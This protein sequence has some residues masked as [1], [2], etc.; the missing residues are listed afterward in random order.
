MNKVINHMKAIA[1]KKIVL[2]ISFLGIS[3]LLW[4]AN[5]NPK[6]ALSDTFIF[7]LFV[8]M[9]L[10][11][12]LI[13]YVM[14]NTLKSILEISDIGKIGE[15]KKNEK[16]RGKKALSTVVIFLLSSQVYSQSAAPV[17][18][19]LVTMTNELY[20][21]MISLNTFLLGIIITLY[22]VSKG[23]INKISGTEEDAM[24]K[25]GL[26]QFA[27]S[28]TDAVPV[29]RENEIMLDHNYDGIKELDN[30]LPPWW[31]YGFYL[32]IVFSV[33][34]I[35][36]YHVFRT[37][38]LQLAEYNAQMAEAEISLKAFKEAQANLVDESNLLALT[39]SARIESGKKVFVNNC[40]ICH[41]QFGEGMVGPNLTDKYW[42]NG[43]G[44]KNIFN[45]IK[46]GI[47]DKGM[48]SWENQL[49]P[50]QIHEV[51]S[52]I[53]TLE[54]TNPPNQKAPE[55]EIWV[56][57]GEVEQSTDSTTVDNVKTESAES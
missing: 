5:G 23:L 3:S 27:A 15:I 26:T 47:P 33:I 10:I 2:L 42:K 53:L 19:P 20:W 9:A 32:T 8:V 43:G 57:N 46:V 7:A 36:H 29:E 45:T 22:Y 56:E 14:I 12:M 51:S 37:G 54:G 13:I 39:E 50:S 52:Y 24:A 1:N 28:L 31:K 17:A 55:G 30:N 18:E 25:D 44:I 41:G 34:Y 11:F 6:I 4:S 16:G 38:D 49:T 21:I 48:I 40:Q 35:L